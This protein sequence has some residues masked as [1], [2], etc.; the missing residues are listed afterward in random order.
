[1]TTVRGLGAAVL[2]VAVLGAGCTTMTSARD[3][4]VKREASCADVTVDIYFEPD[5]AEVTREGR[6][7][8]RAAAD[9]A[10]GCQVDKVL[11]LGLA[12]AAGAPAANLELSKQRATSVTKALTATGL[13]AGEID[14]AAAGQSG[15]VTASGDNRPLRRRADVTLKLSTPR[16]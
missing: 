6:A 12:D 7:V 4:I 5:S 11:V 2:V 14:L 8:L 9:Q 16:K 10:K 13:P 15:S 1:M 3:R